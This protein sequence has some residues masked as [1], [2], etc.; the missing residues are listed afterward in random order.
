MNRFREKVVFITGASSGI[1]EALARA[2]AQQG[3]WVVL[4]A[5]RWDRLQALATQLKQQGYRAI[6][7]T[8]DVTVDG[9]L[10]RAI[11]AACQEFGKIDI[12]IANSGFGVAGN[13]EKLDLD[14]Y[15]RQ[16][17]T[18]LFGVLRTIY[19]S[20][21]EL[22]K[23]QGSLVLLGSVAGYVSLPGNSAY[24]MSKFAIHGLAQAIRPELK[25]QGIAV[26]LIAP[27]FIES[28]I[29]AVDNY[30]KHH[31]HA[32]SPIPSYLRMPTAKAAQ[33][34]LRAIGARKPEQVI[35]FHGKAAVWLK[36][37]FPGIISFLLNLGLQG[38]KEPHS[39]GAT[40]S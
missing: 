3:A 7:I 40:P 28:E 11:Q 27:G 16:L 35:T 26:T 36:R 39:N 33:Q 30:G 15:R 32:K 17:E 5:R 14:D 18:N 37:H 38:R 10:P 9:D 22:K 29:W 34:I 13:L 25:K 4:T 23:T 20:L 12:V 24:G 6:A 2:F 19:A 31:P 8:C 1:G 21:E